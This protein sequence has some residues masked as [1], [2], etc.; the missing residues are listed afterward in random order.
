MGRRHKTKRRGSAVARAGLATPLEFWSAH[1]RVCGRVLLP[2]PAAACDDHSLRRL[3][4]KAGTQRRSAGINGREQPANR[5]DAKKCVS[6]APRALHRPRTFLATARAGF[7]AATGFLAA[8]FFL[9]TFWRWGK[10]VGDG[11]AGWKEETRRSE[12]AFR[13]VHAM[14]FSRQL[15]PLPP[16]PPLPLATHDAFSMRP[17]TAW[18]RWRPRAAHR[19]VWAWDEWGPPASSVPRH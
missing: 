9:M 13:R 1:P 18:G 19:A 5:N 8:G 14:W 15:R 4:G 11:R 2:R 10:G 7:L 6:R 3:A 12:L 17:S 16:A